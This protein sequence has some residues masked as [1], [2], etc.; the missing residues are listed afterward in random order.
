MGFASNKS[1]LVLVSHQIDIPP[2]IKKM[3]VNFELNLPDEKQLMALIEEEATVFSRQHSNKK[4]SADKDIINHLINN[5]KGLAM[6]DARHLV[7]AAIVDDGALTES[8]LPEVMQAKYKLMNR[9]EVL[10][11]EIK[12]SRFTDLAVWESKNLVEATANVFS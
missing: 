1:K 2:E 3:S 6:N 8:D 5:L 12:N 4:V 9:D 7:R 11:F 10:S